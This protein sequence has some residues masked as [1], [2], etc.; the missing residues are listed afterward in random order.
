MR[1]WEKTHEPLVLED[2]RETEREKESDEQL[3]TGDSRVVPGEQVGAIRKVLNATLPDKFF[4]LFTVGAS[5]IEP[6]LGAQK[7]FNF[8]RIP[9]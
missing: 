8:S 9:T 7:T 2:E 5:P 6:E 1:L 3:A 4:C